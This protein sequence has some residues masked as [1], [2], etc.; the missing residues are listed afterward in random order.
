MATDHSNY[1]PLRN[2]Q[3]DYERADLSPAGILWFLI[4]LFISAVFIELVIWGM[5]RFMARSEALFPQGKQNPMVNAQKAAPGQI[6]HSVLQNTPPVNLAV[7]PEPR[8]QVNDAGEMGDF[9]ESEQKLLNTPQPFT[10][11][12]GNVHLPIAL[13]M[14]LIEQR[15]LPVRGSAPHDVSEQA[16]M[17]DGNPMASDPGASNGAGARAQQP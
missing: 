15:G 2:P 16:P 12:N 13:A 7:F 9:M 14:Q 17:L 11:V 3:V 4:G 10:D 6:P 5:F 1:D 8:L